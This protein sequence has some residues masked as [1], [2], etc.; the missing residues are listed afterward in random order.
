ML[1]RYSQFIPGLYAC[2][3]ADWSVRIRFFRY[4]CIVVNLSMSSVAKVNVKRRW[5]EHLPLTSS[6]LVARNSGPQFFTSDSSLWS[7]LISTLSWLI[8]LVKHWSS[9]SSPFCS[10]SMP[11]YDFFP[12]RLFSF[13]LTCA[14]WVYIA[15]TMSNFPFSWT[16]IYASWCF[17][18]F[19]N[20]PSV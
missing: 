2:L 4:H 15:L 19:L 5:S 9:C 10:V 20:S 13:W 1:L 12:S 7:C 8:D 16:L 18:T 11:S 3:R 17:L 14:R 6:N